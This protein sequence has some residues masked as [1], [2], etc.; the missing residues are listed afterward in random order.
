MTPMTK[1]N[2]T[3]NRRKF[4]K[5][6]TLFASFSI[7]PSHFVLGQKSSDDQLT[8]SERVNLAA[9]G[10]G[11]Q[12]RSDLRNLFASGHCNVVALCDVDLKGAHTQESQANHSKARRFT[13][14]RKMFDE[15]GDEIDAVLIAT[16]DHSHFCI[17]MLAMSL[18]KHVYVEKPLAHTFGQCDRLIGL[19]DRSGVVTQMGNQGHSGANYFQFKSWTEAGIIKDVEH[20]LVCW[21]SASVRFGVIQHA[22]W[23]DPTIPIKHLLTKVKAFFKRDIFMEDQPF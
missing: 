5:R 13:D 23:T 20:T 19:A 18:G 8:P 22:L 17:A 6:S 2:N 3:L 21:T 7:L 12:G 11:N 1:P 15:M 10:I 16:P 14:F 4:L 9:I